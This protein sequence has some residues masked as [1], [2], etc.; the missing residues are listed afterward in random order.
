MVFATRSGILIH[1]WRVALDAVAISKWRYGYNW[2]S[3]SIAFL[4]EAQE[5]QRDRFFSRRGS[6]SCMGLDICG[7]CRGS[8]WLLAFIQCIFPNCIVIL[9]KDTN[10]AADFRSAYI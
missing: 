8:I 7:I 10:I 6:F 5:F 9:E 3:I 4:Y 1:K 2:V